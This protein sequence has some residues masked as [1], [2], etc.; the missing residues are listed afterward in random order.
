MPNMFFLTTLHLFVL[1][2][3]GDWEKASFGNVAR[4][5]TKRVQEDETS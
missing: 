4:F 2:I 5:T 3:K 1:A